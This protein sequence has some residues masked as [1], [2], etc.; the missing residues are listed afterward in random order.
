MQTAVQQTAD[1]STVEPA[2][3]A[4]PVAIINAVVHY[5]NTLEQATHRGALM[6]CIHTDFMKSV[7]EVYI[8]HV[9]ECIENKITHNHEFFT[10]TY[11]YPER[12]KRL[13]IL[14]RDVFLELT[15]NEVYEQDDVRL[16]ENLQTH[17]EQSYKQLSDATAQTIILLK[18][19]Y[20]TIN[21]DKK[22]L[23]KA[24]KIQVTQLSP[25]GVYKSQL[26]TLQS[27]CTLIEESKI[28]VISTHDHFK[29]LKK[30]I[31]GTQDQFDNLIT[32]YE[33]FV[34]DLSDKVALND[35]QQS[36]DIELN[37]S[38]AG[39]MGNV[40]RSTQLNEDILSITSQ[41]NLE[42]LPVAVAGGELQIRDLTLNKTV[43][44]WLDYEIY[45]LL[46]DLYA[47]EENLKLKMHL[48]LYNL[49]KL[50]L[51]NKEQPIF[52]LS[53][54]FNVLKDDLK[55]ATELAFQLYAQIN[56][57]VSKELQVANFYTSKSLFDIPLTTVIDRT[58]QNGVNNIFTSIR[59]WLSGIKN[60]YAHHT[61][62]SK[63]SPL[64]ESTLCIAQRM[65]NTELGHYD[66]LFINRNYIGDLFY[67]ARKEPE[68]LFAQI[69]QQW[70][71]TFAK[72]VLLTG[73]NGCGKSTFLHQSVKRH[74]KN[75]VIYLEPHSTAT[76]DGRKFTTTGNLKDA[77]S[78]VKNSNQVH[79]SR[80]VLCL[81]N[82]ELWHDSNFSILENVRAL[83]N[84][85]EE[86]S[87]DI[88][89]IVSCSTMFKAHMNHRFN[90][91]RRF[92]NI[93]DLSKSATDEIVQAVIIRHDTSHKHLID[94]KDKAVSKVRLEKTVRASSSKLN[95]NMGAVIQ[96]WA[97]QTELVG[98][99]EVRYK[100]PT[101]DFVSFFTNDEITV[102]KQAL[103]Y[104]TTS[105]RHI[106]R[107]TAASFE[108]TYKGAVKRLINNKILVRTVDGLLVVNTL[109]IHDVERIILKK[110]K[111]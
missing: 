89:I 36:Y 38:R 86:E 43:Q 25:W 31:A 101:N 24:T 58:G 80:P 97:F 68:R 30:V 29:S 70:N 28:N 35:E 27:Q 63:Q 53:R 47:I 14:H 59:G 94:S 99:N 32:H 11:L 96:S 109:I 6:D 87:Q 108:T 79:R 56:S 107:I 49:H 19:D 50:L 69:V 61:Y 41:M 5:Q 16:Q 103:I 37:I 20:Q 73:V 39:L 18:K 76:I 64:H 77:L 51:L 62:A 52:E 83:L 15:K 46:A 2:L 66:S 60:W 82:L 71:E 65:R 75:Q 48:S 42:Q 57:I 111:R 40:Q 9:E 67:I 54:V 84:F 98:E 81:D 33:S 90:F 26:Q 100:S 7:I 106:K 92:T 74:I 44:Q 88:F 23:E 22:A 91:E 110:S 93:L 17:I 85:M 102:L 55:H 10:L 12:L 8:N 3:K 34:K 104:K 105:E 95:N 1:E 21:K 45:P 13:A 78:K 4:S 72:T